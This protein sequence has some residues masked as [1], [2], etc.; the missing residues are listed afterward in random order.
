MQ[1]D[2]KTW[3]FSQRVLL[4]LLNP[5]LSA[6]MLEQGKFKTTMIGSIEPC[7]YS[8]I[9][10]CNSPRPPEWSRRQKP[11]GT[12]VQS[13]SKC[14]S[15]QFGHLRHAASNS[16]RSWNMLFPQSPLHWLPSVSKSKPIRTFPVA[17]WWNWLRLVGNLIGKG[18]HLTLANM[19]YPILS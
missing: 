3:C 6:M 8:T 7:F 19:T 14:S 9:S 13:Q 5:N 10:S 12:G 17:V 15:H 4:R 16:Y 1:M 2:T 18:A 11:P